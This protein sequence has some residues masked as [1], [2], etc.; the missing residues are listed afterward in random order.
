MEDKSPI[1]DARVKRILE[2]MRYKTRTEAAEEM[3]YKHWKS[4]DMYMRRKNFVYDGKSQQY[5]PI[6]DEKRF[7]NNP[8]NFAPTK[9]VNII[10]AFENENV[11]PKEIAKKEGFKDHK[12]LAKY[13][14]MKGYEWNSYRNNYLKIVGDSN[15]LDD[16]IAEIEVPSE[17]YNESLAKTSKENIYDYLPF[18]RFIYEQRDAIYELLT[19]VREDGKIPRYA[20]PGILKTK[21]IYMSDSLGKVTAEFCREKNINQR[22]VYEAALIEY[23]KKYGFKDE[24]EF[25]LNRS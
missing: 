13:M 21:A 23:L 19:G 24:V 14:K 25:L 1:Y 2:L 5:V 9:V 7:M 12:E 22:E 11:D 3:N 8:R 6:P 4:L 17:V 20:I 10:D 18:I 15:E 16:A